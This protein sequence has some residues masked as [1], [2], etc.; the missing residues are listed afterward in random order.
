MQGISV[1]LLVPCSMSVCQNLKYPGEALG[2]CC[3]N[4][5]VLLDDLQDTPELRKP[6]SA[7]TTRTTSTTSGASPAG[8]PKSSEVRKTPCTP[9]SVTTRRAR[10]QS[11]PWA[12]EL[13]QTKQNSDEEDSDQTCDCD[14]KPSSEEESSSDSFL[15]PDAED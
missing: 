13:K 15:A 12:K 3:N 8:Q 2:L 14:C 7:S 4:S 6:G 10:Q 11:G 5:T 9:P 1:H